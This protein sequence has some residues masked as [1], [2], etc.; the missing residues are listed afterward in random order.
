MKSVS[1]CCLTVLIIKNYLK[2]IHF[3]GLQTPTVLKSL[4]LTAVLKHKRRTP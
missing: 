3:R 2:Y 4:S 1:C